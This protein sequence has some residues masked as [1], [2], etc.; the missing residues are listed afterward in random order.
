MGRI[1]KSSFG[2]EA[3]RYTGESELRGKSRHYE[4]T[5]RDLT[6]W[7]H[8]FINNL[9]KGMNTYHGSYWVEFLLGKNRNLVD[10]QET[11]R[12]GKELVVYLMSSS[13]VMFPGHEEIVN[14]MFAHYVM[15]QAPEELRREIKDNTIV[16]L[17][18]L[19]DSYMVRI[20]E[21]KLNHP[22]RYSLV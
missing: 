20:A 19:Y 13:H 5:M 14:I 3:C 2:A 10:F 12:V 21:D 8:D 15:H 11:V 6:D 16:T 1:I 7:R 22:A 17:S 18:E 9:K 4:L